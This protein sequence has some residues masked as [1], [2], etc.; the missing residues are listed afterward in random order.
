MFTFGRTRRDAA[1]GGSA[2]LKA[3]L[4]PLHGRDPGQVEAESKTEIDGTTLEDAVTASALDD[5]KLGVLADLLDDINGTDC[6]SELAQAQ[7]EI[8]R[9]QMM[10]IPLLPDAEY[11]AIAPADVGSAAAKASMRPGLLAQVYMLN[12]E[13]APGTDEA[14]KVAFAALRTSAFASGYYTGQREVV[15]L[16]PIVGAMRPYLN[17][18]VEHPQ[19]FRVADELGFLVPLFAE[20]VFRTRGHHY[21][22]AQA[23][24]YNAIYTRLANSALATVPHTFLSAEL[25][26]HMALHWTSPARNRQVLLAQVGRPSIPDALKI[27]ANAAPAGSA[28]IAT[29]AAVLEMLPNKEMADA[30]F[31]NLGLDKDGFEAVCEMIKTNPAVFHKAYYAY[32]VA[33]PGPDTLAQF[34]KA[35]KAGERMAPV[36]QGFINVALRD[37]DMNQAM[38]L[39]KHASANPVLLRKSEVYFRAYL[40]QKV[41]NF[42]DIFSGRID[43][44]RPVMTEEE[45]EE[46]KAPELPTATK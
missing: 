13:R 22:S 3:K 21:I 28:I 12:K 45:A 4:D 33:R 25:V 11:P 32:G 26:Y 24:S 43:K 20:F 46:T 35:H 18:M 31:E 37:A 6:Y 10:A 41:G 7:A 14:Q 39:R 44:P 19:V 38:A 36:L 9:S 1:V 42:A 17:D 15:K 30:V 23:E 2:T 34:E 16:A 40:K 27:R 29:S 8:S 5:A